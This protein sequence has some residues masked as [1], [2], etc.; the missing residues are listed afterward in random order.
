MNSTVEKKI[1]KMAI[2]VILLSWLLTFAVLYWGPQKPPIQSLPSGDIN[3]SI[4]TK[5]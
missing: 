1:P 4:E 3:A 5:Q 2:V